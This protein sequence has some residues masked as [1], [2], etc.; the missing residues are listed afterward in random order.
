MLAMLTPTLIIIIAYRF[1]NKNYMLN[2]V[3]TTQKNLSSLLEGF[4]RV[5]IGGNL[6]EIR[7]LWHIMPAT[8]ALATLMLVGGLIVAVA[9]LIFRKRI[10]RSI[11]IRRSLIT[12]SFPVVYFFVKPTAYA[13]RFSAPMLVLAIILLSLCTDQLLRSKYLQ[14]QGE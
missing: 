8:T 1:L 11:D 3:D 2:A 5:L 6:E 4:S 10:F 9:A 13:P 7:I 12:L 14:N